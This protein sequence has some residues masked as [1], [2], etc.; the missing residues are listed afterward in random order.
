MGAGERV[1]AADDAG[2]AAE[3][4]DRHA[5]RGACL[6]YRGHLHCIRRQDDRVRGRFERSRAHTD[7]VRIALASSSEKAIGVAGEDRALARSAED[8]VRKLASRG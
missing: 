7:E 8:C 5:P 4:H 2:P 6:E 3:R 1:D